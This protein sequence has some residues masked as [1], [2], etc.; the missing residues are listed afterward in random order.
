V[1]QEKPSVLALNGGS[2]SIRFALY[3]AGDPPR[4]SLYGKVDRVGSPG[5]TLTFD[6]PVRT[7]R[8]TRGI[9]DLDHRAAADFLIVWLEQQVGLG[10]I[11]AVGHRRERAAPAEAAA[12]GHDHHPLK[13]G[14]R[15][16][17]RDGD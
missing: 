6:D 13:K 9:G 16:K 10:S 12:R 14:K 15:E 11:S 2:S 3:Q 1:T 8:D 5:T 4:R 7:Q 17:E